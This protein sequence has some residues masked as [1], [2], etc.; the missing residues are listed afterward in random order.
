MNENDKRSKE[1]IRGEELFSQG[2]FEEAKKCFLKL[3]DMPNPCKEALNNLGV[4]AYQEAKLDEAGQ[5]FTE[6]LR[7]DP[8]YEDAAKNYAELLEATKRARTSTRIT[9][10]KPPGSGITPGHQTPDCSDASYLPGR[11]AR[12][13][14]LCLPGLETFLGDIIKYLE[15][16]CEVRT[17]YSQNGT[18][19][20]SAV[21]WADL[22]WL[23]WA[24][25]LAEAITHHEGLLDG[26]RVICRV[27][28]YE[29]L[30]GYLPRV[31][32]A[33]ITKTI[34]V[35]PHVLDIARRIYPRMMDMTSAVVIPNG[36]D[37]DKFSFKECAPGY[38]LAVVGH[39]NNK[40]NPS[41]WPE[42]MH[43]LTRI[44]D[45]YQI[46]IAGAIQEVRYG[47]YLE[48]AF[49]RLGL[50]KHVQF[51][52][53]VEN[54]AKWFESEKVNYLL[55]TSIFESFGYGIAEAMAMGYRPL[56]NNFPGADGLWPSDCLFSSV[57]D[58]V[59][60]V[61]DRD[62]YKPLEY[63]RFVEGRYSLNQQLQTIGSLISEVLREAPHNTVTDILT[64]NYN[65]LEVKFYLPLRNDYM[66]KVMY[67]NKT[68]YE[69]GMLEDIKKRIGENKIIVDIGA[70]MGNHTIYFS[71]ICKAKK[72]YSFEPQNNIYEILKRNVELNN[73]QDVVKHFNMGIGKEHLT[74]SIDVVDVHNFGMSK[75]NKSVKGGIEIDS[76]DNILLQEIDRVDM[77]KIDVEGMGMD[78]LEGA[79]EILRKYK[80]LIYIEAETEAEFKKMANYLTQY[81][82]KPIYKFNATPTYL[83]V[84][85]IEGIDSSKGVPNRPPDFSGTQ[86]YWQNRYAKGGTSGSGSYGRLAQFKADILNKF[87]VE[88]NIQSVLE[89]GCGDGHQLSL[90]EFP[91]Y[92]GLDISPKAVSLCR[93]LFKNDLHKHFFLYEPFEYK[94]DDRW[95]KA[96]MAIS[97]DV[98]YHLIEDELYEM[99]MKHL[100]ESAKRYVVIYSSNAEIATPSSHEKRRKF[101]KWIEM[102]QP[103]FKLVNRIPN[104]FPYDPSNPENTSLS[105]FYFFEKIN[106]MHKLK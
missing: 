5:Y 94:P 7:I 46:K 102:K 91:V 76:L 64:F 18:E 41:L 10:K 97:L 54:I 32:W 83:F 74:A 60:L 29:V 75:I 44:D 31:N 87:A 58:L 65:S 63:R 15:S 93:E 16:R 61:N 23:E 73:V 95:H 20:E 71:K 24:N 56:I 69:I 43:R 68:F 45:R 53:H 51:F 78:V 57:D 33:K 9:E 50:E 2:F 3:V 77:I 1:L 6:S 62:A 105:D 82:Y 38:T 47:L 21:Q 17:C 37:L 48:H 25:Q 28:S 11:Q 12:I 14:V 22:I 98:I 36:V 55:T 34:F 86:S 59:R 72:V 104:R 35:A 27:H 8:C 106:G 84:S 88:K 92:I 67:A 80:P 100:F 39:V 81:A 101:T 90:L 99:Y 40:K 66:R 19:L 96:D 85:E 26:K 13:A 103:G 42:I 79:E 89:L 4:L 30:D 70:F 52:G 49:K